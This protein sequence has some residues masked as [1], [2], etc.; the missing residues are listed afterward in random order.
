M[1]Q[2][3]FLLGLFLS[4]QLCA[5]QKA[6]PVDLD[7][8]DKFVETF[9]TRIKKIITNTPDGGIYALR[10]KN[11]NIL[12]LKEAYWIEK[13]DS[14][15]NLTKSVE[16]PLKYKKKVREFNDVIYQNNQLWFLTSYNN[17]AKKKYYLFGQRI[18]ERLNVD[19]KIILL[20]EID[21]KRHNRKS[22]FDTHTSRDS[23]KLL[24]YN[25]L[26][27]Q[28]R[29]PEKF[30]F[31]V[32]DKNMN[33][34]WEKDVTLPYNDDVF[35]IK[36]YRVDN[37][38]NVYILGNIK[39]KKLFPNQKELAGNY[40]II[41][42]TN[43]GNTVKEYEI[44]LQDNQKIITELT[45]RVNNKQELIIAGF[46]SEHAFDK[47]KGTCYLR[48][49]TETQA[50]LKK[51]TKEFDFAFLTE[52]MSKHQVNRAENA[53][54]KGNTRREAELYRFSLD[55]LILRSDGGSVLIA[56]QAYIEKETN[57]NGRNISTRYHYYNNDIIVVNISPD[58][59]ID[60]S[61]RIE[62]R[63]HT[64]NDSGYFSSYAMAITKNK[65]Y[66]VYNENPKNL[67]ENNYREP[68]SFNGSWSVI[69][70]AEIDMK[71]EVEVYSIESN[72][73]LGI[74]SR[75]KVCAQ[76]SKDKMAIYGEKKSKY[77]FG[78]LRF[79]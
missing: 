35:A 32:Y 74:I 73:K 70:L 64:I 13:Y 36:D 20:A 40:I 25:N 34:L 23:T 17:V 12:T 55:D 69:A 22:L 39:D 47:A 24:V 29:K 31:R 30:A 66:F 15:M 65:L 19:D 63:Q 33:K 11:K 46:Y 10:T 67:L 3:L 53:R 5:Q 7:W 8:G 9:N 59:S 1:K 58:G 71:G 76:V 75:P 60:W 57:S 16:L 49:D 61:S 38:G 62:K 2:L 72:K 79:K 48:I 44:S 4:V 52:N 51:E 21:S 42:Y 6:A 45:F 26:A 43:K 77:R 14:D 54:R 78:L 41:A 56:E 27:Y 50:I 18:D 37:K 28:A 68:R